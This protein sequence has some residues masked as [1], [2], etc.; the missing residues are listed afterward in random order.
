MSIVTYETTLKLQLWIEYADEIEISIE[1]PSGEKLPGLSEKIGTQ[2]YRTGETDLL[3][4][5]GKPGPFQVT[6]E[7]ILSLFRLELILQ[8]ES[9]NCICMAD[10][11]KK[12]II[13]CGFLAEIS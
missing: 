12:E 7:I 11:S 4:Y 9:G 10:A 8:V 5:Y 13:I 2:R 1:T 3:I 6:Q